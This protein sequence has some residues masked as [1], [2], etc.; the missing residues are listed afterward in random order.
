MTDLFFF[1]SL[2]DRELLDLVLNR[3]LTDENVTQAW[4]DGFSAVTAGGEGYPYL[5]PRDG[6]RA[7]GILVSGLNDADMA[8]LEY[9]EEAEYGLTPITV[10]TDAGAVDAQ[11]FKATDRLKSSDQPWDL[12]IWQAQ[13]KPV[14]LEAA[15]ELMGHFGIVP[16]EDS[17]AIWHGIMIRARMRARAK[18]ETPVT[19]NLR[20]AR[21]PDDVVTD[22]IERPYTRYFAIEEH[23]LRHRRFD[24]TMSPL[25]QRTAVTSGDAV[26]IVPY[27][28]VRDQV[29]LIEQFRAPM[30]ARGDACPWGIEAIAG[31]IDQENDAEICARR[32][33]LEEG[34]ITLGQ[35]EIIAR[36]YSTPGFAAEHI[37]SYAGQ[38]DLSG[39][40]GVF[41]VEYEDED[42]RAFAIPL[43]Q[44]MHGVTTGEINNAP[45]IL[46]I[47]W[48]HQNR[49]RLQKLWT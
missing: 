42:I 38:A 8:R 5:A 4:I 49:A 3:A 45:A 35:V 27:D 15:A 1:G 43:D 28:P 39:Q 47:L 32:E 34:G 12:D 10:Q 13:E 11:Y 20:P 6:N 31:R 30:H 17:N 14:A 18:A 23:F 29:L 41:G 21:S 37:T 48:L 40:G 19:G 33:A 16:L 2:R 22:R 46:S 25:I 7:P 9:Y 36:Y 24:G 44:A 26:T